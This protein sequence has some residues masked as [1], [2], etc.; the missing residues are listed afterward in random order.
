MHRFPPSE[1]VNAAGGKMEKKGP[2]PMNAEKE[3]Q[4]KK[5]EEEARQRMAANK[6]KARQVTVRGHGTSATK[7][8]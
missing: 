3:A 7:K 5:K 1:R 4:K 2:K 6:A 8:A